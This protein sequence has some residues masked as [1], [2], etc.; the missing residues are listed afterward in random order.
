[1]PYVIQNGKL[2]WIEP[3]DNTRVQKTL[4]VKPIPYKL[5]PGETFVKDHNG[6]VTLVRS[7]NEQ[8]SA[9]NRSSYQKEQDRKYTEIKKKQIEEQKRL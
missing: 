2:V 4:L 8:V 1:M 9:D 5:K 3:S 7:K 6:K